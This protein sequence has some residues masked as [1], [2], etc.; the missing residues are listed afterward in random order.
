MT[1]SDDPID[2]SGT[3][4]RFWETVPLRAMTPHEWEA[5]CDG[6]GKCCLNKL[7]DEETGEVALTRVACR[8][9]DAETCRCGQYETRR[10]YVP[11]CIMLTPDTIAEIAY[12]L[13]ETCAYKLLHEGQTLK[14]WHPLITGDPNSVHR[15]GVSV[16]GWTVPEFE[17][18]DDDLED[19]IIREPT[20]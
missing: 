20:G 15:A 14:D 2:R 7:E 9:L 11:E 3:R 4:A 16:Q 18:D 8:L 17:V 12:W 5:L 19:H 6:C 10:T 1:R 13:P